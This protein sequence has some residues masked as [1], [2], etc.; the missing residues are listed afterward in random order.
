M[1]DISVN[2]DELPCWMEEERGATQCQLVRNGRR[3]D[4]L[5]IK[6]QRALV[7]VDL[8]FDKMNSTSYGL[9]QL[10]PQSRRLGSH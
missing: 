9:P 8:E 5:S 1:I 2:D 6:K 7:P 4:A 3:R 10:V